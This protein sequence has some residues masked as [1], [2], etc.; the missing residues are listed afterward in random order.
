MQIGQATLVTI[1]GT[2]GFMLALL[3]FS[4]FLASWLPPSREIRRFTFVVTGLIVVAAILAEAG[5]ILFGW[6]PPWQESGII[7]PPASAFD[8]IILPVLALI[9]LGVWFVISR[10]WRSEARYRFSLWRVT[11]LVFAF[12]IYELG[13]LLLDWPAPWHLPI[14]SE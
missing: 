9:I 7:T 11:L 1:L 4:W 8:L 3:F 2:A 10:L 14:P 5:V 6:T 13:M 12:L